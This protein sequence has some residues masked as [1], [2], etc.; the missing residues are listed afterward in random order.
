MQRRGGRERKKYFHGFPHTRK[1]GVTLECIRVPAGSHAASLSLAMDSSPSASQPVKSVIQK[2][3]AV[4]NSDWI[5]F[6][7]VTSQDIIP[8]RIRILWSD[9]SESLRGTDEG[10]G[11]GPGFG[12]KP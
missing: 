4:T 6:Q 12:V 8:R 9:L 1:D 2:H 5:T 11:M 10:S 3:S 7:V